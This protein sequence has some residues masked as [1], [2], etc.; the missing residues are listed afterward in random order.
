MS[1][2]F[3]ESHAAHTRH[4]NGLKMCFF[5]LLFYFPHKSSTRGN[6]K[7][8]ARKQ[9]E[10]KTLEILKTQNARSETSTDRLNTTAPN[11]KQNA[12]ESSL[13]EKTASVSFHM[14]C[15]SQRKHVRF[16]VCTQN[17][18][19]KPVPELCGNYVLVNVQCVTQLLQP[20]FIPAH[21]HLSVREGFI[22]DKNDEQQR[23]L[24][25]TRICKWVTIASRLH[26]DWQLKIETFY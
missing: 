24:P 12:N 6:A 25:N 11:G 16:R 22:S 1:I 9:T 2:S 18:L 17:I 19:P 20:H 10:K 14:N 4:T 13:A 8:T 26:I 23:T 3:Y 15:R 7:Q 5:L 21:M